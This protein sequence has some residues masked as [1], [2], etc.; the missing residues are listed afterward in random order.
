MFKIGDIE[1]KS[2]V[3]VAPMAGVSNYPFRRVLSK[4]F[5][6]LIC[7][8]MVSDKA[9]CYK[10]EKTLKMVE[11]HPDESMI[12]MQIFGSDVETMVEAAKFIDENSNCTFIDINMGCPVKKVLKA[13][14]G[15]ELLKH[16]DKVRDIVSSVV[17]AVNKPVT[18]KIRMG[19]DIDS[20]NYL[21]IGKIIE[22]AGASAITLHGRTRSQMYEG[23]ADWQCIANLKEALSIPVIGNGDIK[24]IEDALEMLETTNCDGI[25]IGRGMMGNPWLA[26]EIDYYL[27][28]GQ[29]VEEIPIKARIEQALE[30]LDL[31]VKE[32]GEKNGVAQ[33]RS[34]GSWYL[35]GLSGSARARQEL[36]KATSSEEMQEV[37]KAFEEYL[38]IE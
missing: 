25:M 27:K 35:K 37:F 3:I 7:A 31:L 38:S 9:L 20:I 5:D 14:A 1:L 11:V 12:S 16:P 29:R 4:Y 28:T 36:N 26:Y 15:S 19:F 32:Y 22:E 8:E 30:H 6:G 10:N 23:K 34:H 17:K 33:M 13:G 21:E 18:V 24:S 2:K